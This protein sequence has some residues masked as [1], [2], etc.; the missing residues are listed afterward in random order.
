MLKDPSD[1]E[2]TPDSRLQMASGSFG[3]G[4]RHAPA[5]AWRAR[6]WISYRLSYS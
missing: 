1:L 3:Q 5:M 6:A 4:L 2:L